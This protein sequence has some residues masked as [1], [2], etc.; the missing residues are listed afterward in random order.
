MPVIPFKPLPPIPV[1]PALSPAGPVVDSGVI[2]TAPA[3]VPPV[4]APSPTDVALAE[5]TKIPTTPVAGW[6]WRAYKAAHD[7]H[8]TPRPNA[9]AGSP[10]LETYEKLPGYEHRRPGAADVAHAAGLDLD[11]AIGATVLA[12]EFRQDH[13]A[14]LLAGAHALLQDAAAIFPK[15]TREHALLLR[16]LGG[17]RALRFF[18]RQA[19][20]GDARY[21]ASFQPPTLRTV[22]AFKLALGGIGADLA[23]GARRWVDL[24]DM[25]GGVQA[26]EK[27]KNNAE[28]LLRSRYAEGWMMLPADLRIDRYRL[29]LLGKQGVSLEEALAV[30]AAGRARSLSR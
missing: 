5:L 24:R 4:A 27:L 16:A 17:T 6:S 21:C 26:G 9:P 29:A 28:T 7:G 30:V 3:A 23:P 12:S 14:E 10:E 8:L 19:G 1:V 13:P 2:I 20:D 11:V 18:G 22:E 15:E 25:D